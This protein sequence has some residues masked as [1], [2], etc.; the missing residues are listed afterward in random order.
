MNIGNSLSTNALSLGGVSR[1]NLRNNCG[2][3]FD[4]Y[5]SVAQSTSMSYKNITLSINAL[6]SCGNPSTGETASVYRADEYT[7][8]NP[9]M[10]VVGVDSNGKKYE[11]KVNPKEVNPRNASYIEMVALSTYMCKAGLTNGTEPGVYAKDYFSKEDYLSALE[12]LTLCQLSS[13]NM[14]AYQYLSKKLLAYK[15]FIK[16]K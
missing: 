4:K 5:M 7:E 9:I 15:D 6:F 10:L 3:K 12:D 16:N 11:Q 14:Q 13:K 8:D 2:A 1:N